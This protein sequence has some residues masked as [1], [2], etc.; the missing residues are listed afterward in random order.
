MYLNDPVPLHEVRRY[1]PY[2]WPI[3]AVEFLDV[4]R[5]SECG[6]I[7]HVLERRK[8][9]RSLG[10]ISQNA[11]A[12][13]MWHTARGK[14]WGDA[15]LG[16]P[17]SQRPT[18]SAGSIHPIH[19]LIHRPGS[20]YCHRYI[21]EHHAL[22]ELANSEVIS[23]QIRESLN[24]FFPC[25]DAAA[26]FFIAEPGKTAAKYLNPESLIWRDAGILQGTLSIVAAAMNLGF[27]LLGATGQT[28]ARSLDD[29]GRLQGVGIALVGE[30]KN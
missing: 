21:P 23:F 9:E 28:I 8:T 29:E 14:S 5:N 15:S 22:A 24:N 13:L 27:C 25:P 1:T 18:P 19:V 2:E 11:L 20:L 6:D 16:F 26:I 10:N 30:V 3:R 7:L 12:E 4:P 17:L